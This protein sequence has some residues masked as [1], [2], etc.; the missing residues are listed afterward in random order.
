MRYC[1][2]FL[3]LF[4]LLAC[5][6]KHNEAVIDE[7]VISL[8]ETIRQEVAPDKRT[9]LFAPELSQRGQ[10]ITVTGY[11]SIPSARDSFLRKLDQLGYTVI[12]SF[13]I[14]PDT[15]QLAGR[16][17]GLVNLSACNIRSR[18]AHS[19]E[20][21]TQ[22]TLGTPLRIYER[23][24]D[25]YRVQT[26]DD[27]FG[28]LDAGGFTILREA[29]FDQWQQSSRVVFMPDMGFALA[30]P[31]YGARRVS[32]LIAGNIL[33]LVESGSDFTQVRF[34]DGRLAYIL[35]A[36]LMPY[37]SWLATRV[38]SPENILSTAAEH[39]GRPYLWGGTSG[40]A[41]D[42]SGFTKT[43]FYLN[44]LLLPRDAS[45]QVHVGQEVGADTTLANLMPGDLLFFGRAAT[46]EQPEKITHVAIYQGNGKIIHASERVR[47]QSLHPDDPDFAPRRLATFVRAKRV[48][49]EAGEFGVPFLSDVPWYRVDSD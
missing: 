8:S 37:E 18:P 21:S 16:T 19:A 27:Y 33:Q 34:P 11:T 5:Q 49:A 29:A 32:D 6:P 44:G 38:P 48:L 24:G 13:R 4:S 42:C 36:E 35:T 25:W 3:L 45:Q 15:T 12:D 20:L 2:F 41:M 30:A 17:R 23:S 43:V 40:K 10:Q 22:A 14:L 28:W 47:I 39:L 1:F 46:P 7:Q 26:P 9:A 31:R